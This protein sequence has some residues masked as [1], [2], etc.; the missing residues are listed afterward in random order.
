MEATS[1][2]PKA[3][4][5]IGAGCGR[6]EAWMPHD[7]PGYMSEGWLE[8]VSLALAIAFS[9]AAH[10]HCKIGTNISPV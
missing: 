9:L 7:E 3:R 1:G 4:P 8:A 2:R 10:R 5:T 6:K